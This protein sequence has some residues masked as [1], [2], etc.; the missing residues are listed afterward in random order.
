MA[1]SDFDSIFCYALPGFETALRNESEVTRIRN[2]VSELE[3]A[4]YS[5][6]R[7]SDMMEGTTA[8]TDEE[9]YQAKADYLMAHYKVYQA[10]IKLVR[11]VPKERA[12]FERMMKKA[13]QDYGKAKEIW[14]TL[15]IQEQSTLIQIASYTTQM[16][17]LTILAGEHGKSKLQKVTERWAGFPN[18]RDKDARVS[19]MKGALRE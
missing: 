9:R 16:D 18:I 14:P 1:A 10:K 2:E 13:E 19:L 8:F 15:D 12:T 4:M 7:K 3:E 17:A 6:L 11:L 5:A